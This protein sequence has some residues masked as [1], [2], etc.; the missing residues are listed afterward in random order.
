M[1]SPLKSIRRKCL[2]CCG[3]VRKLVA[4]CSCDG[5]NS[6]KCALWPFRFGIRPSTL[7]A[8]G[9]HKLLSPKDMPDPNTAIEDLPAVPSI[10]GARQERSSAGR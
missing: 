7:R 5:V 4:Y 6:T 1:D 10:K 2:D 8:C 3:N 9:L